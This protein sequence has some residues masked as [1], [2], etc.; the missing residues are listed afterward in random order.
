AVTSGLS[1]EKIRASKTYE[2]ASTQMHHIVDDTNLPGR[3]PRPIVREASLDEYKKDDYAGN[4]DKKH[5]EEHF[6]DHFMTLFG[7]DKTY[8]PHKSLFKQGHHWGLSVDLNTCTGCNA[9]V[10]ACNI[11][12][13]VPVVG[14]HEVGRSHEMHWMRID[15]YYSIGVDPRLDKE[16]Y[17]EKAENPEV[18]FMPMMCQHC[19]N[20]PCE[21]VC[22]VA[23]TNHSS[24]GLN[25]M[26]YNR[27]IGTRYCA[28]NCPFKV[29]RFNWFDYQGADSFYK[30]TVF[31]NDERL[32]AELVLMDDLTRMVLNPDV[33]VRSRGVMEKC[34][35]CVQRIQ[36]GKL[37]AKKEGR[38]LKD[39]EIQT[40][41]QTAC[42]A[43]ALVFGDM[44]DP[45]SAVMKEMK[46]HRS[47]KLL[48][49]I[50]VLPS[51][52]YMTQIRNRPA[53]AGAHHDD[54]HAEGS[55]S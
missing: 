21:N 49:E 55:H 40:A 48:E 53:R 33:T 43:N 5:F 41:C 47:Y 3:A 38:K 14:K 31:S 6:D 11:E 28:N 42:P 50:H 54:H 26:A 37:E 45:E 19:D 13:N 2:V 32:G 30:N 46:K 27:C 36:T 16:A 34:S 52:N 51:V 29:R 1:V 12:N 10:T 17:L 4:H 15:R 35:F 22:P 20:A 8:G 9:C 44:N 25:Q 24:E 18:T 39:G 7:D 23:A